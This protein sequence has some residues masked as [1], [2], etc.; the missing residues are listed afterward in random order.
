MKCT[1]DKMY[2][3]LKNITF[4]QQSNTS[5]IDLSIINQVLCFEISSFM[6]TKALSKREIDQYFKSALI[7]LS[8]NQNENYMNEVEKKVYFLIRDQKNMKEA[9][10]YS[11]EDPDLTEEQQSNFRDCV[12]QLYPQ[13]TEAAQNIKERIEMKYSVRKKNPEDAHHKSVKWAD[14]CPP[15]AQTRN[16]NSSSIELR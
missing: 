1:F 15:R 9:L 7:M 6:T 4:E 13:I 14:L 10:Y 5:D 12:N 11:D 8:E 3:E 2:K 16:S